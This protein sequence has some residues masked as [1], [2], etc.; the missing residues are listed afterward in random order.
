MSNPLYL[1]DRQLAELQ[2][3]DDAHALSVRVA[4]LKRAHRYSERAIKGLISKR[5]FGTATAP[6]L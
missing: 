1:L 3:A 6:A 2:L 5:T 4:H